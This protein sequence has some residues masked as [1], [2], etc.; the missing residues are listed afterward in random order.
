MRGYP[1]STTDLA[2]NNLLFYVQKY[3]PN[4]QYSPHHVLWCDRL[5]QVANG[6]LEDGKGLLLS[7]PPGSAKTEYVGRSFPPWFLGYFNMMTHGSM[8]CGIIALSNAKDLAALSG[9]QAR[10]RAKNDEFAEVF[11]ELKFSKDSKKKTEWALKNTFTRADMRYFAA[12]MAGTVTGR[13]GQFALVDDPIRDRKAANSVAQQEYLYRHYNTVVNSRLTGLKG[14]TIMH[15]RWNKFDLI[16][17]H[18]QHQSDQ[19]VYINLPIVAEEEEM[20]PIYNPIYKKILKDMTGRPYYHRDIG[21]SIW[22]N[23]PT[24]D[25][26]QEAI[27]KLRDSNIEADWLA[28]YLGRPTIEG[29]NL[30]KTS[31]LQFI[32]QL[33]EL[34]YLFFSIDSA[35]KEGEQNAFTVVQLWGR[36]KHGIIL[37]GQ[38][39]GR[40]KYDVMKRR[41][42]AYVQKFASHNFVR[43]ILVEDAASGISLICDLAN[44][45]LLPVTG[46]KADRDK[47]QRAREIE[48]FL[49]AGRVFVYTGNDFESDYIEEEDGHRTTKWLSDFLDEYETFPTSQYKDQMDAF[50]HAVRQTFV[51]GSSI[52]DL[53]WCA[54][55][56][57]LHATN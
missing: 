8:D 17:R 20:F 10:E 23:H 2:R 43:E 57:E 6:T 3:N 34:Q 35:N 56:N 32:D 11:C 44:A 37:L 55:P 27:K 30:F 31:W 45:T 9:E 39:R 29:G 24:N 51:T 50:V 33:P 22:K 4:Y 25:F 38:L 41:A 13:R 54:P 14:R 47:V 5:E 52:Y 7:A 19:W 53:D 12:G 21:E 26:S 46:V 40:W 16:G 28:L 18:M 1:A 48:G 15:T 42:L 49:V 36:F